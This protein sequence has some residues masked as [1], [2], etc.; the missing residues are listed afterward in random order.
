MNWRKYL[1]VGEIADLATLTAAR[2][3]T[4]AELATLSKA[5]AQIRNRCV[6]RQRGG[7]K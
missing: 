2:D 7:S 4:R 3:S 1:T 6:L 5:I